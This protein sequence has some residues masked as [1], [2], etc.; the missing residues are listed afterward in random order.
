MS[1]DKA[2]RY[3]FLLGFPTGRCFTSSTP[4]RINHQENTTVLSTTPTL[5]QHG[6]GKGYLKLKTQLRRRRIRSSQEL[7][8]RRR[9]SS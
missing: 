6:H 9:A 4:C 3:T 8:R 1:F 5:H 2:G 7:P